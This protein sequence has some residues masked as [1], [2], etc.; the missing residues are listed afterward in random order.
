MTPVGLAPGGI[1]T[2]GTNKP[3]E[4]REWQYS[5]VSRILEDRYRIEFPASAILSELPK[6]VTYSQA[7]IHYQ[8]S[9]EKNGRALLVH[10]QLEVQRPSDV[11]TPQDNEEWKAFHAVLQRDLRSQVFYR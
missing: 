11:C 3:V 5:C 7:G 10:R 2:L 4:K 1:A 8:S 6:G 9:Y